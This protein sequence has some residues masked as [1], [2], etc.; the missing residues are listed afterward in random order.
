MFCRSAS[1]PTDPGRTNGAL[2]RKGHAGR[3]NESNE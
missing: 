2:M 1:K 3:I